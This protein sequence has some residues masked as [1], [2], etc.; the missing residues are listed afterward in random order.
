MFPVD[1]E[2]ELRLNRILIY[3]GVNEVLNIKS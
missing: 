2:S 1:F 3:K